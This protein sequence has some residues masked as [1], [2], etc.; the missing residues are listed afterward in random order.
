MSSTSTD[1]RTLSRAGLAAVPAGVEAVPMPRKRRAAIL[2]VGCVAVLAAALLAYAASDAVL[3]FTDVSV[4]PVLLRTAT[5]DG[6]TA[7]DGQGGYTVQAPGWVEPDPYPVSVAALTDGVV[8]EVPVLEG[9][10]VKKGDVVARMV[11]DDARIALARAEASVLARTGELR[12]AEAQRNAARADWEHPVE[13]ARAVAAGEAMIDESRAALARQASEIAAESARV[14]ELADEVM[15]KERSVAKDAATESELV[16]ARLK[17]EAHQATLA[18]A[19]AGEP[20]LAARVRQQ[21]AEL[22]AARENGRLRITERRA[23]E[24]SEAAVARADGALAEARVT[25]DEA[26]LR[27]SRMEIRSP[28]DGVVMTRYVEPGSTMMLNTDNPTSA[29]AARLYDPTKLQVR[30]DIPLSDAAKVAVG[31]RAKVIVG[32]L[33]DRTFDGEITRIVPQGDIQRN[34]LQVKVRIIDP[35]PQL[36]PDMLARVRFADEV[37]PASTSPVPD[38][39]GSL[40]VLA[41]GAMLVRT[42]DGRATAWVVDPAASVAERRT[43]TL[44]DARPD[45]WVV[46]REGLRAG[47]RLIAGD[48]SKLRDGQRVKVV[49]EAEGGS[50]GAH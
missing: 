28:S 22:S 2:F 34:T 10:A 47:D 5:A 29:H 42:T 13:R 48:T 46:I 41:P 23:L 39:G 45:G 20:V 24:E 33:P 18:S 7:A 44:S 26:K 11:D 30:V 3:P 36:R 27:L 4:V 16:Q 32:V 9:Q 35:S 1:L 6:A 21:E 15:R 8:H 49:G 14:A 25:R 40:Q 43:V 37:T 31:R 17:L 12:Q 38:G 19:K 50:H